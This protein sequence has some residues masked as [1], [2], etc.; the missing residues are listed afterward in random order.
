MQESWSATILAKAT[1]ILQTPTFKK[2]VKK[3][4]IKQKIELDT[5]IK[6]LLETPSLSKQKKEFSFFTC[7]QVQDE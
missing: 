2:A 3:L 7:L 1:S 4:T 6:A 5:A